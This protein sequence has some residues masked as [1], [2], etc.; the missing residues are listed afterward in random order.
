MTRRPRTPLLPGASLLAAAA[1]T[2]SAPLAAQEVDGAGLMQDLRTLAADSM[3]GRL[4]GSEGA[5]AARRHIV[6]RLGE[7]GVQ[8]DSQSF[9]VLRGDD[10]LRGVNLAALLPGTGGVE[11]GVLLITAHYDHLGTRD[12]EVFNGADDNASGTAALLAIAEALRER[13]LSHTAVLVF[14]DAEEGGLR[15]ARAFVEQAGEHLRQEV[16]L[17]LN[18]DMVSRSERDLWVA[19]TWQNPA[20]K[21]V[22]ESVEPAEGV[23]LRFGHDSPMWEGSDN[24]SNASDHGP[25]NRA[26]VPFL[27]FGVEDHP[28]YHRATDTADRVDASWYRASVETIL[29]VTRALDAAP[30]A[31]AAA[32]ERAGR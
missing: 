32:R 16:A 5:A 1:L 18:L 9:P 14:F 3:G 22:V 19:G 12:G 28:D 27:Y 4:V 11:D 2:L 8:V 31:I 21:P 23:R 6:G 29:R 10:Q 7:L 15:G 13:P 30:E 17:N 20:L 24:W 26:G 25:F